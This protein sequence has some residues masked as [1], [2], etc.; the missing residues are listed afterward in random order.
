MADTVIRRE[1]LG[2]FLSRNPF[3]HGWTEG[4][5][6]REKMRAIHRIAPPSLAPGE[7]ILEIGG[8]RSGLAT[9]LYPDAD[10]TT[11]DLDPEHSLHQPASVRTRFVCGRESAP[12]P[13]QCV[14][15]R[16]PV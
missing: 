16:H 8:G 12:L 11:L 4:L 6:Y 1:R 13:R 2:T 7:C 15:D 9:M 10:V 14:R 3:A 5:F